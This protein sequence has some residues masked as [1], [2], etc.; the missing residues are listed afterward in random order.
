MCRITSRPF[1]F[2]VLVLLLLSVA[3]SP[4]PEL[5]T[6]VVVNSAPGSKGPDAFDLQLEQVFGGDEN[7]VDE[8]SLLG[9]IGSVGV[10]E[11]GD[12]YLVDAQSDEIVAFNSDGSVKWRKGGPGEGPGEIQWPGQLIVS[13]DGLLLVNQ[14]GGRVDR[15]DL[16]GEYKSVLSNPPQFKLKCVLPDGRILGDEAVR[17]EWRLRLL[18]APSE[19]EIDSLSVLVN[20]E[21]DIDEPAGFG[22]MSAVTACSGTELLVASPGAYLVDRYSL[23]GEFLGGFGRS[24]TGWKPP[25][26]ASGEGAVSVPLFMPNVPLD[27]GEDGYFIVAQW[28]RNPEI[29]VDIAM[30]MLNRT[31]MPVRE[32]QYSLDLFD[33]NGMLVSA[34]S[35]D[36]ESPIGRPF[37][38]DGRGAVYTYVR[39]PIPQIRRYRLAVD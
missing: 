10:S 16:S 22:A 38:S 30:A 23:D 8:R 9:R 18:T 5:S 37:A 36:G 25:V 24:D 3:C 4:S 34:V 6:G 15:Y 13:S 14:G 11:S 26:T 19:L 31:P 27:I 33:R 29:A 17:D 21:F 2:T 28:L 35:G 20:V 1:R 12:V 32:W 39:S 7:A